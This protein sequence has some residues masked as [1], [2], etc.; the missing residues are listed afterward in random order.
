ME[1]IKK[2][3]TLSQALKVQSNNKTDP[4]WFIKSIQSYIF[5]FILQNI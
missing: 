3:S 1:Q 5:K 4:I 2:P